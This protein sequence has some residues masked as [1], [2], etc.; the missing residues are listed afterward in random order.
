MNNYDV[1]GLL[2]TYSE[3]CKNATNTKKLKEI[4]RELKKELN[5]KEIAKMKVE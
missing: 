4:V 5:S 3:Q 2:K 1:A